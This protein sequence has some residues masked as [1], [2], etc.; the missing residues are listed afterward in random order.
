MERRNKDEIHNFHTQFNYSIQNELTN[1][2]GLNMGEFD[3][4]WD[5]KW[6]RWKSKWYSKEQVKGKTLEVAL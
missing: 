1:A 6:I 5:L 3:L 4:K 2:V